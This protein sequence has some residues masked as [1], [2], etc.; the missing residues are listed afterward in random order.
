MRKTLEP[1]PRKGKGITELHRAVIKADY[2]RLTELL[3]K[4]PSR[5]L[6][7]HTI[8]GRDRSPDIND[9][10]EL[11]WTALHWAVALKEDKF[12]EDLLG[13]R[14]THHYLSDKDG[15]TP[16]HEAAIRGW[17]K[18]IEML[19]QK[20]NVDDPTSEHK[21]INFQD[22]GGR[23][24]LH[25]SAERGHCT[26]TEVLAQQAD[27]E[28][29][30]KDGNTALHIAA[31]RGHEKVVAILANNHAKLE[32]KNKDQK[33]PFQAAAENR[34]EEV[35]WLFLQKPELQHHYESMALVLIEK[36]PDLQRKEELLI[37]AAKKGYTDVVQSLLDKKS[38]DIKAEG[39]GRRTLLSYA[40]ENGHKATVKLLLEKGA[41]IEA[42]SNTDETPLLYAVMNGDKATIE[43]LLEKGAD[44]EAKSNTGRTPLSYAVMD[45]HKTTIELLLEKGAA[46]PRT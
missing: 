28:V 36:L 8:S 46:R 7:I 25:W 41:A 39:S 26:V 2:D 22:S 29:T 15:R 12:V 9:Q 38:A 5:Q 34:Y 35:A 10:D 24:A 6:S 42:K 33:T 3:Q 4:R 40:A 37:W 30:D 43:L 1:K 18:G 14:R 16:L 44:I 32:P 27:R 13:D 45:G 23:T 21:D 17:D 20:D 19:L 31:Q 11:G